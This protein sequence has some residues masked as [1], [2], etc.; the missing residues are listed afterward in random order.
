MLHI[1]EH[2]ITFGDCLLSLCT[3][4]PISRYW[5]YWYIR[6]HEQ[7]AWNIHLVITHMSPNIL[8]G[9]E[10][11]PCGFSRSHSR[12]KRGVWPPRT[13]NNSSRRPRNTKTNNPQTIWMLTQ[14]HS[15]HV[16][17]CECGANGSPRTIQKALGLRP[18]AAVPGAPNSQTNIKRPTTTHNK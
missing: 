16:I 13:V 1:G 14:K 15:K 5:D 6:V 12:S 8:F 3:L 7:R 17:C 9:L 11:G 4:A 18:F 10:W 2:E